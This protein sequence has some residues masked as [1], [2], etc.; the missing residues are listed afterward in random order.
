MLADVEYLSDS[1]KQQI[2]KWS[3][4][5]KEEVDSCV[6]DTIYKQV[7]DRSDHEAVC[8]WDGTFTYNE[9]WTYVGLLAQTLVKLGIGPEDI[10]PLCF[11]KS[12]W[13]VVAML[14][15]MEA[16]AGFCPLDATQPQSRLQRLAARLE[17]RLLLCS[18]RYSSELSSV[19]SQVMPIDSDAFAHLHENDSNKMSRSTSR[20]VAYVLWTSGSTGEPKGVIIEHRAYCSSARNHAQ[21][22]GMNSESRVLL[23]ASFVFDASLIE[24]LTPLM[25]GATVCIPSED[26]R[27]NDLALAINNL[28]ADWAELTP[29]VVNFLRPSMIPGLKTLLLMGEV[30]SPEHISTWSS[31]RLFNGYG[32]AECSVAAIANPEVASYNESSLIGWSMGVRCWVVDPEDHNKLLPPGCVGELV[33]EG[34]TL[35]R[36]YLKDVNRT[37]EAFIENPP[38]AAT[39]EMTNAGRRMYKT[40]DLVRYNTRNGMFYFLGRKDTQVKLHGQRVELGEIEHHLKDGLSVRQSLVLVP[41]AGFCKQRLVAVLSLQGVLTAK[42]LLKAGDLHLIDKADQEKADPIVATIRERLSKRLPSFM[43]PSIWLVVESVPLLKSGKLD[44]KTVSER[45]QDMSEDTF[46]QWVQ[47]GECEDQPATE[48]ESQLRSVWAHVLN[49]RPTSVSLKQS[50]LSLGGDSISAMMVQSQCKK[51][52]IGI[53]VQD[54]LKAKSLSHLAS[55]AKVVGRHARQTERVEEPFDLS[56]IQSLYFDVPNRGKGHF[57]QSVFVRLSR[58]IQSAALHRAIK[59]IINRHSM[60]RARFSL[61]ASDGEWKQRITTDVTSSYKFSVHS[62]SSKADAVPVMS[63]SQASLDPVD[64]PLFAVDLFNIAQGAQLLFMTGHHLVVDLVSWRIILQDVEELL[65]NPSSAADADMPLSFQTWCAMQVEHAHRFP[66]SKVLPAEHVPTQSF[67]YWGMENKPNLYGDVRCE[68]FQLD[69]TSTDLITSKCHTALRTDTLDVLIA[70][71]LYSFSQTFADRAPP[72]VFNEG[73]GRELWDHDIDLSRTVGWFTT[74][75]PIHVPSTP[76][77]DFV[78]LLRRVKDF[79]RA[80]PA[81][82]RPYFASRMLTSKGAKKFSGHWPLEVA[83][84]YLG[85]YQQLERNDGLLLPVEEMAGEARGAGGK[86]DVGFDTPRFGL[87]EISAVVAQGELR[88]SFTFNKDMQHQEKIMSWISACRDTLV[89]MPA[90]LSQTTYQP[91][92]SDFPLLSLTYDNLRELM[93]DKLPSIGLSDMNDIEDIYKCSQIQQGLLISTQRDES[94]Y[95][96]KYYCKINAHESNKVEISS[97]VQAWQQVVHRHPSLRTIFIESSSNDEAL[98]DQVVLKRVNPDIVL[99]NCTTDVEAI[100]ELKSQAPMKQDKHAPAH[101]F[102]ICQTLA[103]EVFCKL[104]ISHAIMDG[105]SM[106]I[107]FRDLVSF[108][109]GRVLSETGP[110]YSDYISFL[111]SQPAQAGIGYWK[112]HLIDAEPTIFPKLDDA[113]QHTRE[114]RSKHLKLEEIAGIQNFCHLHGVTMANVFHTAWALTLRCYTGSNDV[115]FGYLMSTR[116]QSISNV[117]D[118]V[119]YLV[120]MLVCRVAFTAETPLIAVMQ[121]VQTDLSDGQAHCQTPLSEILHTLKLSGDSL[122]NTILSFRKISLSAESEQ[123]A[124]SFDECIP[125]YDPTEYSVSIN[126]EVSEESAAIDLDYWTDCLSDGHAA[127]VTATF[128]H[129]LSAVIRHS[130]KDVGQIS[131]VSE[132]DRQQ[133]SRWNSNMPPTINKCVHE[134]VG[135]QVMLHPDK[136]AVEAWDANF[137]YAELDTLAGR[138]AGYLNAHGIGPES[139]VC[140]CF[141]KSAYTVIGMLGVLQAGGAF[142]SLDPMHPTSALEM[143]IKDTRAQVIL[144]SPCYKANFEGLDL[145]VVSLDQ[146]FLDSLESLRH[147]ISA[148]ARPHN[149]AYVIYTSGSTG[150][151]KGVVVE[152]RTMVTSAEAHG[153]VLGFGPDSRVLQFSSYTFDN[154][155]EEIFTTLMRGGLVC[156]PSDQERLNDLA[157]AVS[158]FRANFIDLTPTVATYLNPAEMPTIKSMSLGGEAL[159]KTVLEVWGDAVEIHNQYGPSECCINATH[160]IG[161]SSSSEPSS[162]GHSVGS[163]SW[164]VDPSDHN[165]LLAVGCEGELLIEGPILARGYLNNPEKTSEAFI[166]NP[167]WAEDYQTSLTAATRRMYKTGDLVRYNSDGTIAYVGRK[168]QQVKLHGQRIELGEIEYHVRNHLE[169]DWHFAVELITPGTDL[170]SAKALAVFVCPQKDSSVCATVPEHGLLPVSTVLLETFKGLETSLIAALPKHMVP[171]LFIPLARLPMTSSGK[172]DRKQLR[173]LATSMTETQIAMCRLA[174]STGREPT[175]A[176]EKTLA[177]LWE[178]VLNL[179]P[180]SIGMDAQFV[181]MG[182]DSIAAIRLVSA[183]RSKGISLT[184]ASIF[185]N[186]TLSDMCEKSLTFKT[187]SSESE[188]PGPKP[189]ELLS[190]SIPLDR[191]LKEISQQCRIDTNQVED[192]YPCTSIQEGLIASSNKQPGAYVAENIY[193]ISTHDVDRFKQAWQS[194]VASE[195]ILRT[196]VVYTES[197]GFLQVVMKGA[198]I[199]WSEHDSLEEGTNSAKTIPAYNGASL[200]RYALARDGAGLYFV[201]TMHHALYDGWSIGLIKDKIQTRYEKCQFNEPVNQ[202]PYSKFMQYVSSLDTTESET[203]CHSLL[204]GTTSPQFPT[205]PTPTYQPHVS[206]LVSRTILISQEVGSEITLP[207]LIRAAWALTISAYSNSEDVVY[208]ETVNGRDAPV[209]GILDLVG[210]AFSTIPVRV[211]IDRDLTVGEYLKHLHHEFTGAMPF[212]YMG[213]Q[214]IR[215]ISPDTAKACDF[216]NLIAINSKGSNA[217]TD[218]W[219]SVNDETAGTNFYTFALTVSFNIHEGEVRMNA[220]FDPNV[221]P[222]WQIERLTGHFE[223]ALTEF[224]QSAKASSKLGEM[225]IAIEDEDTIKGWNSRSPASIDRCIHEIISDQAE[226]VADSTPAIC[227]WDIR[228]TY[229]ELDHMTSSLAYYLQ[230]LGLSHQSYVPICFEK[231]ALTVIVMIAVLKTGASFVALDS[232]SPKARLESIVSDVDAPIILSSPKNQQACEA[233]GIR[234]IVLSLEA[235]L[236]IPKHNEFFASCSGRDVAY[237]IFTSGSTGKPKGT[238]IS[239]GA[240]VSGAMAHGPAMHM[241]STSRV[242]QF[243]S[244]TFDASILEIFSTLLLGGCICIPDEQ[245]RLSNIT[246]VISDMNVNWALLTP[247][248]VQTIMPSDVPTLKTLVLGGEAMAQNH[249]STWA[250]RTHLVNAYGPSECAVVATV[251]SHVSST[252]SSSNIGRAV[253]GHCFIVDRDSHDELVPIGTIGELVVVGPILAQGYLKNPVKTE[254]AF[255]PCPLWTRKFVSQDFGDSKMYKTGDLVKYAQ[256]GS[257]LYVGRKDNQTKLHGQRLELGDIEHHIGQMATIQHGLAIIPSHG[258]YE[259]K[260]VAA[261]SFKE[262]LQAGVSADGLHTVA[263]KEAATPISGVREYLSD[264]LPPYMVPSNWI[265]FKDIPLLPS[266]KLDRRQIK[267]WIEGMSEDVFR[268]ISGVET[269]STD[270]EGSELEQSLLAIW[271]RVLRLPA[272]QIGLNKNFLYLGGDSISALQVSSQCRSEG[273]GVS[274]QDIIRC[275][276]ISD[277]ATRVSLPQKSVHAEEEYGKSFGLSPMQRLFF[278]WV[279]DKVNHFNQSTVVRLTQRQDPGRVS[280]SVE[281]LI[282]AHSMLKAR[283]DNVDGATWT[284]KFDKEASNS[285]HFATHRGTFSSEQMSSLLAMGQASLDIRNGPLVAATLFESDESGMQVFGLVVHHLVVDVVSWS[286]ILEDLEA[287]LLSGKA[288]AQPSLPFQIWSRLQTEQAE[289]EV[290][291]QSHLVDDTT[292]ADYPFWGITEQQNVYGDCRTLSFEI[293]SDSTKRLLG[294]CLKPLQT[295]IVDIILGSILYSFCQIFPERKTPPAVFNEAH[296]REPWDPSLDLTHTVGWF[297]TISPV[298]LPFEASQENDIANVIRWVKDLRSRTAYKGRQYFA[299]RM[300]TMAGR[301]SFASHWPMEIA[302]NYLGQ[303]NSFNRT[304]SLLQ[305]IDGPWSQSD[306]GSSVPRFALFEASARVFEEKLQISLT[307]PRKANRQSAIQAWGDELQRCLLGAAD[308]LAEMEPQLTLSRFPLLPMRYNTMENLMKRLPLM[309][310]KTLEDIEDVYVSSPMQK[311]LLLSQ[312][313]NPGQ[314]MYQ[315][316]FSVS[317]QDSAAPIDAQRLAHAWENVVQKHSSLRTAFIDSVSEEGLLDQAVFKAVSPEITWLSCDTADPAEQL[318]NQTPLG[319][320]QG[321]LPHRLTI[322]ETERGNVLCM[323]EVSHA[324]CDGT[325]IAIIVQDLTQ[326]YIHQPA[327]VETGFLYRDYVSHIQHVSYEKDIAYWR[328]YLESVEPCYFPAL[329][330]DTEENREVRSLEIEI[331]ATSHLQSFCSKHSVT[332]SNLLQLVW[333]LVLRAYTGNENI[334]FGYLTSGRNNPLPK[335]NDAV[336]LFISMLVCRIDF[337]NDTRVSEVLEQIKNDYA[338]SINHQAVSLSDVQHELQLSGKSLFNTAFTFQRRT[339]QQQMENQKIVFEGLEAHDPSE[340]DVTLNVEALEDIVGVHFSYWT[341]CLS[342]VQAGRMSETFAQILHSILDSEDAAQPI[343]ALELCNAN[344]RNQILEWNQNTLPKVDECVHDIIYHRSQSLPLQ[345]PAVCSWDM[346]MTY[347]KLMSLSKRLSKHLAALGVGAESYVPICFG[348]TAWAVVAM[349][350]VLHAGGAFVPLDPSHP[351]SRI[352]YILNTVNAK[353]VLSSAK[354]SDK[355]TGNSEITTFIVDDSLSQQTPPLLESKMSKPTPDNAAYLIFTSGTTGLPKGTIISHRAFATGATEHAPAILMRQTSRVLQ[356]SN[357]CFDASVMEI[358]TSLITGAC[359]CIPSDEERMNDISGAINRM[360][361][362]WTLLTP[363]VANVLRPESV[364]SLKVLV[365]GGEAMQPKHIAKWQGKTSLVNAYGPSECA[366]IASASIKV[367]ERRCVVNDEPAVIGHA[368]GGRSWVV[369]PHDH[370]QLMPIG[371]V[372]ELVIEG[373]TVARGYLS[374]EEK[375]AKAFVP[376][377]A[378][379]SDC[380]NAATSEKIYKTGDLV[381]YKSDG[382]LIYIAR[383]DTQIK[384]NG[385]RIEL[386][387]IEYRV[388]ENLPDS[389]QTAVEMVAPAG[390]QQTLAVFFSSPDYEA[391]SKGLP[392]PK[393]E[394]TNIDPLLLPMSE[395]ATSRC[396]TLKAKLAGALPAYMIPSLFIPLS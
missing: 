376:R 351:E 166:E 139:Y 218:F 34:H 210:P 394:G 281:A 247:S 176:I 315:S 293:G 326:M 243:A 36:G 211:Q 221:I 13:S 29:S 356:F 304:D 289:S 249:L 225:K 56:P 21:V 213:I 337:S 378:W 135:E 100:E 340:F 288:K 388:K 126:V 157:G 314:Y 165:R 369:N 194:V 215:R 27:L 45:I 349:L 278:D 386:G 275:P 183:A 89:S 282:N 352:K 346:D 256:D 19:V 380:N 121:Q 53:T 59:V 116:D 11:E 8:A 332:Q 61:S 182:G 6:H 164:I 265:A 177:G 295:D 32:P 239:H 148:S 201:W 387:E 274:V 133:I 313:K 137:T 14:A 224:N 97:I 131:V 115:S 31:I 91:T 198:P 358:L 306:I 70:S 23:Y 87:F 33:I 152:H 110:L 9:L 327:T 294:P 362:N 298:F 246:K 153:S 190:T 22:Y 341:H 155:L 226:T 28:R 231:S 242:L 233:L 147:T 305:P 141:E 18:R 160:R 320:A 354:Y 158:R 170:A 236:E 101:R 114:L 321:R 46:A 5:P 12:K 384:L 42:S 222:E 104:D 348:K 311:G 180:G 51:S 125:Y 111:Q 255:V 207:S 58:P 142:V 363:S 54:I 16:G 74:M 370:N 138:L 365:T 272:A 136:A 178:S 44:R 106:S 66:L 379:M 208:A 223:F 203:F 128:L 329:G 271:S 129:A 389:T 200:T 287:L 124:I 202:V 338:Q 185:R 108:Y 60:L 229:Q 88:F 17:S 132:L 206:S 267:A 382:S 331:E 273:L 291:Q 189:F 175:T 15:V 145:H 377:P 364:P 196:R 310:D 303:E 216:Q 307:Y 350:G 169:T 193:R 373:Y 102:T 322:C 25:M 161:I 319:F 48:L 173:I 144:T 123:H 43:I 361:V 209:G 117:E 268:E 76:S 83:F 238:L 192:V 251:N 90:Q 20:N 63:Q 174:G 390:Q 150:K 359:V 191:V 24:T 156:V 50:F 323:L 186:A 162:I 151:P 344:H 312:I 316:I 47:R 199:E 283:F 235:I 78:D 342:D 127:N 184:V 214:R 172:L 85:K 285:Y 375:T 171:S 371:T 52:S 4:E 79:R 98:Y 374:N 134:V 35:A 300:Q 353:L 391:P 280:A 330:D 252:S 357:L 237:I 113:T 248:F 317:S 130:E 181:R 276:S 55:F 67:A 41:K 324:I 69:A 195:S 217:H 65:T 270:V 366:V 26:L 119:G 80:V 257:L 245:T 234:T 254:E 163:V 277:L 286:I 284:Q 297:T 7:L 62:C 355:F 112:T 197:L 396:K 118:L 325:S 120:N 109:E 292:I 93:T 334:C 266:G 219:D 64:G 86:A 263:S 318:K 82:G 140:L 290:M 205:L 38:W 360:S 301:D 227:S 241:K 92:L 143:R 77:Q 154:T 103:G 347:V 260:L 167:A 179:E 212:Q 81:N 146:D 40:G 259:K 57:N 3:Q 336:G 107:I 95:A 328:R 264:R 339:P 395:K 188:Q 99:L 296:G 232:E 68:G 10:V 1:H 269:E 204:Q 168:D 253:G 279:S 75:Y 299:Q 71:M 187:P 73:H 309:G 383:K 343:G 345:T 39:P 368:V 228:L 302:F 220:H 30:M 49:L 159:T 149:P 393:S 96:V 2:S 105:A 372:G 381:R 244:Y 84:N 392:Q 37:R 94:F 385:L 308:R 240:F 261:L 262:R 250:D 367:N 258:F 335:I 72:T 333:A 122:F 230:S